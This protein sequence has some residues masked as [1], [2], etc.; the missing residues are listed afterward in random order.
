MAARDNDKIDQPSTDQQDLIDALQA[1]N[2]AM[3]VKIASYEAADVARSAI[4]PKE[5]RILKDCARVAHVP[6]GTAWKW[7]NSG[8]LDS[9]VIPGTSVIMCEV[10]SLIARRM[11]TGRHAARTVMKI[12]KS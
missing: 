5:Y 8:E 4:I 12:S 1:S 9:F 11:R 6:Y 7:H 3:A 10:N 2:A